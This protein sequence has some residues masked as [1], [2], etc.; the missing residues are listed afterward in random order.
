MTRTPASSSFFTIRENSSRACRWTLFGS[1]AC[2]NVLLPAVSGLKPKW[3]GETMT[4]VSVVCLASTTAAAWAGR[5]PIASNAKRISHAQTFENRKFVV[6]KHLQALRVTGGQGVETVA[7]ESTPD[8]ERFLGQHLYPSCS[9]PQIPA[10]TPILRRQDTASASLFCSFGLHA[11]QPFK[12][13][14]GYRK[15]PLV[16]AP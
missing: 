6:M 2:W 8:G 9:K 10:S 3:S 12:R 13:T 4:T 16:N 14:C 1:A 7:L 5:L 11:R 15:W